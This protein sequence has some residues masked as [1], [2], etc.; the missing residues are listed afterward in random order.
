MPLQVA[1]THQPGPAGAVPRGELAA[2][3]EAQG[4]DQDE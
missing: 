1:S 2:I 3:A 4:G